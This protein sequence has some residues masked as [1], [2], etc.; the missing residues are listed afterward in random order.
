MYLYTYIYTYIYIIYTRAHYKTYWRTF[1][2][3][4]RLRAQ[5]CCPPNASLGMLT[6]INY[7]YVPRL[8]LLVVW[9]S[10][11]CHGVYILR[12]YNSLKT[13]FFF[14]IYI[15]RSHKITSLRKPDLSF[16]L[17]LVPVI[18]YQIRFQQTEILHIYIY[19][20]TILK[21]WV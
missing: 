2:S 6:N 3:R 7:E 11:R 12:F 5:N 14:W 1:S 17:C 9:V 13:I 19:I 16:F 8:W 15:N 4:K 10:D 18:K 21:F 20:E